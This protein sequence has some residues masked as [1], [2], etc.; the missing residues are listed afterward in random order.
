VRRAVRRIIPG[1]RERLQGGPS[2]GFRETA[3]RRLGRFVIFWQIRSRCR[4]QHSPQRE[5]AV[6][7]RTGQNGCGATEKKGC[8]RGN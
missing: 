4:G 8:T 5:D 7:A 3:R 2:G 1:H 6:L